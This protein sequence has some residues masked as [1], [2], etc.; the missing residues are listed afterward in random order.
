MFRVKHRE[1]HPSREPKQVGREAAALV[2][3][4]LKAVSFDVTPSFLPR[5]D[6]FAAALALWG[7]STNLTA[8]PDDPDELAFHILD[9]LAPVI[10]AERP[11]GCALRELFIS[12]RRIL[13]LG[14]GAGFPGLVLAAATEAQFTLLEA[15]RKRASFLTVAA[16]EMGLTNVAV[17]SHHRSPKAFFG[18]F[19]GVT[20]RAF[21]QPAV[22]YRSAGRA[23]ETGGSAILY[24]NPDQALNR[25]VAT[26]AGF[27]EAK[28]FSYLVPRGN[29]KIPRLLV[30]SRKL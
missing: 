30:V 10:L 3:D 18:G 24:A 29:R 8:S 25:T 6:R 21:A 1:T 14:S 16:N 17:D 20:G 26:T 22:F 7:T 2:E 9:S 13:D 23:L 15:R 12:G 11:E 19:D 27:A 4:S 5:I 28:Q